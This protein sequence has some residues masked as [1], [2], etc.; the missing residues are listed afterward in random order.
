MP[1]LR[2]RNGNAIRGALTVLLWAILCGV[3]AQHRNTLRANLVRET[4]TLEIQQ[5]FIYVNRSADSLH[6]LYFNDWANAYSEKNT[7]L[8]RRFAEEFRKSLHLARART[9]CGST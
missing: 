8:A 9:W 3:Q 7:A 2:N 6:E 1:V 5:E 4:Q